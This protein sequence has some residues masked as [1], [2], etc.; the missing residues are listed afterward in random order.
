MASARSSI[1]NFVTR[2]LMWLI[3]R[4]RRPVMEFRPIMSRMDRGGE[5]ALPEGLSLM[6]SSGGVPGRWIHNSR[7]RS[8]QVLLYLHGGA[9]I[10]RLPAGHTRMVAGFCADAGVSAF[11]PWYRLA[12]EHTFPAAPE[13][14]LAAYS[15]LLNRGH[16][17]EDIVVMGD[18]AGGNLALALLHL[19]RKAGLPMPGGVIALSPITDFA[20]ISATWRLNNRR[21]PMY[22]VQ[23]FVNPV[24]HYLKGADPLD[25]V[26]SPY[27]GDFSG[28]PTLHLMV[29]SIEA[30][31][32]DSVG[33]ARKAVDQ[34]IP[35][36]LQI[37]QGMPH[38]F[39]L[40][41][42]LPETSH[43]RREITTWIRALRKRAPPSR[44]LY[45]SC[46][47][48]F[49]VRAFSGRLERRTNDQYVFPGSAAHTPA[50]MM[51]HLG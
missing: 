14:C 21:D 34:G 23:G 35:V 8:D 40:L 27:Y 50:P 13:D 6:E 41:P 45:R 11:M 51:E 26:A 2:L 33:M 47:E 32:D 7:G 17:P 3:F 10:M 5:R 19:I 18:S 15:M 9:F 36:H 42:G 31:L 43:A 44:P 24:E 16:E 46:V 28:F 1:L 38:V 12:P 29:G 49:N 48:V 22:R 4:R 30:L 20:Q 25:P 39:T 37:W